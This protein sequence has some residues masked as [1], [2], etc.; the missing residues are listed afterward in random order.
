VTNDNRSEISLDTGPC[1]DG[2]FISAAAQMNAVQYKQYTK[3]FTSAEIKI[4]N[5]TTKH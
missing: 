3:T 4:E 1:G 5:C 2:D